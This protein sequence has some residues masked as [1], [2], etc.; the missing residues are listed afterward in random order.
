MNTPSRR[1]KT[2]PEPQGKRPA[3]PAKRPSTPW[4]WMLWTILLYAAVGL[5]LAAFPVPY[6]IWSIALVAIGCQ[7]I[8]LVGSL[9]LSQFRWFS[10]TCLSLLGILGAGALAAALAIALNYTG[11]NQVDDL[12]PLQL[13]LEVGQFSLLALVLAASCAIVTAETGDR[14][15]AIYHRFRTSLILAAV[16]VLGLG[17][18]G[19]L[20]LL[21]VRP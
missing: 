16:C 11:S 18:G 3:T 17:T 4:V 15:K 21:L 14:L 12:E 2:R 19:I 8:A 10:A 9:A 20:G 6:W 7:A 1:R 13:V 5:I